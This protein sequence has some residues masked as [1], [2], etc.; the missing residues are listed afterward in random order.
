MDAISQY[1]PDG[2]CSDRRCGPNAIGF[3]S[4]EAKR[5]SAD[6]VALDIKGIVDGGVGGEE[7]L[8]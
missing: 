4:E 1:A 7:P 2:S 6:Q 3:G 8:G 5:G